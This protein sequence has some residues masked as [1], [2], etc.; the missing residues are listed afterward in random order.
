MHAGAQA[1]NKRISG[2]AKRW[3]ASSSH[4]PDFHVDDVAIKG[5]AAAARTALTHPDH[6]SLRHAHLHTPQRH[7]GQQILL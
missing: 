4:I 7:L 2:H 3:H 6:V 5:P 1:T